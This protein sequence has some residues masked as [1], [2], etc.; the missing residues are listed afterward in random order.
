M[1]NGIKQVRRECGTISVQ[2]SDMADNRVR[3]EFDPSQIY[4][5]FH[6]GKDAAQY[7]LDSAVIKDTE[8][9]VPMDSGA[10]KDSGT[11]GSQPGTGK[12]IYNMVYARK[13]YYGENFKFSRAKHPKATYKW[14]E[15]SKALYKEQWIEGAKKAFKKGFE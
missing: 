13:Q 1:L 12:V 14:F 15:Q 7:A 11:T 10:L 4:K 9:F 2:V 3:F 8:P 6:G 5:K